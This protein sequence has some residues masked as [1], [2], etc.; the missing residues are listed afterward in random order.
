[1]RQVFLAVNRSS[2]HGKNGPDVFNFGS[3]RNLALFQKTEYRKVRRIIRFYAVDTA[4]VA[5]L[6]GEK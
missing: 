6:S 4:F 5:V 1:M 3:R 2:V